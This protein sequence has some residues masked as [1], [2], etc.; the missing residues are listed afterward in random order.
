MN[1]APVQAA[2]EASGAD[3]LGGP[4]EDFERVGRLGMDVL[5][6]EGLRPSS[7]VLDV[8]CGALRLGYW[9][10]RFL[11]R[12]C[13]FGIEPDETILASGLK[14]VVEPDVLE[15]ADPHFAHNDDF[16]FT[17][18]G[19]TFDFVYARSIWTHAS[20]PQ[21]R[22]MIRSFAATASDEGVMVASYHST[23][24]LLR[25]GRRWSRSRAW[26]IASLPLAELSP[27]IARIPSRVAAE[28][29]EGEG[30]V[31]RSHNSSRP[32]VIRHSFAWIAREAA[33][34]GLCAQLMPYPVVNA[35]YWVRIGR[36][37]TRSTAW[38]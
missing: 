38:A 36:R 31:G 23:S 11:D 15:R 27:L 30:W 8:G 3:F 10:M 25:A 2:A 18:F 24:R 12:G 9:L 17:G 22:A 33:D 21:I 5:L 37:P 29:Y 6:R 4:I 16:D 14:D 32:G 19:E 13:Y 35:Q 20:K 28:D 34:A 26:L 7:R 1:P